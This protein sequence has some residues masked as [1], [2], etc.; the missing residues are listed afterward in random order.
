MK[1]QTLYIKALEETSRDIR[2]DTT[3]SPAQEVI[4][5]ALIEKEIQETKKRGK[6]R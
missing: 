6:E 2:L 3:L 1:D 5:I 4:L